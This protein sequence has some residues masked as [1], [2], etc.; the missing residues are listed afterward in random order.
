M[1]AAVTAT[2]SSRAEGN[3]LCNVNN[4]KVRCDFMKESTRA[5]IFVSSCEELECRAM[6]SLAM[7]KFICLKGKV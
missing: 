5:L 7:L 6:E 4:W 2:N 3:I 1:N